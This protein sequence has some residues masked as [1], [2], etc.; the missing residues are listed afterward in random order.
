MTRLSAPLKTLHHNLD[1]A[2]AWLAPLPLRL[3][4]AWEF[5]ES[6]RE[7]FNGQNWF[8]DIQSRFPFPFDHLPATLNWE[9]SMWAE[10][11]CALAILLAA[12]VP[13]VL[14]WAG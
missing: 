13:L 14:A 11:L 2:G 1:R 6:G 12:L 9:L 7:K 10:L 3:F 4:I 8:E 5:F